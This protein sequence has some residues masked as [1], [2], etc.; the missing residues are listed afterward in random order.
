MEI[1]NIVHGHQH[2]AMCDGNT[3]SKSGK[4]NVDCFFA[5]EAKRTDFYASPCRRSAIGN[6]GSPVAAN[7]KQVNVVSATP[8]VWSGIDENDLSAAAHSR[9]TAMLDATQYGWSGLDVFSLCADNCIQR[10]LDMSYAMPH[11][12]QHS[13]A[14]HAT[15]TYATLPGACKFFVW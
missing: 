1:S 3:Y 11:R 14:C 15:R 6:I 7:A 13:M 5:V 2:V 9:Q 12:C 4:S 8:S 10:T